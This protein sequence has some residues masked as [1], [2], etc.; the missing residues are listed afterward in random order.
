MQVDGSYCDPLPFPSPDALSGDGVTGGS[1][2]L[3]M[4]RRVSFRGGSVSY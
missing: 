4:N 1:G 3:S 2:W